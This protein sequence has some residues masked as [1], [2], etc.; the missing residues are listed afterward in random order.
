MF[1]QGACLRGLTS[2]DRRPPRRLPLSVLQSVEALVSARLRLTKPGASPPT[3][4]AVAAE[5]GWSMTR[6]R[7]A[8]AARRFATSIKSFEAP[9]SASAG[10][11][12]GGGDDDGGGSLDDRF[13]QV[14]G[15]DGEGVENVG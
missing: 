6:I 7:N 1:R 9:A 2:R 5:L 15:V 8:D 14:C 4:E 10:G 13:V 12:G 3:D 11:G